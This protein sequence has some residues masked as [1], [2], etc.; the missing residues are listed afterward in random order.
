[1][2]TSISFLSG[3]I[4]FIFIIV[5]SAKNGY[6]A[7]YLRVNI[8]LAQFA[9]ISGLM[10]ITLGFKRTLE[11][12]SSAK[13]FIATTTAPSTLSNDLITTARFS[14]TSSAIWVL[15]FISSGFLIDGEKLSNAAVKSIAISMLYAVIISELYLR[16]VSV[17]ITS[18]TN[19]DET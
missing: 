2:A 15:A 8:L 10:L 9:L 6:V 19:K 7:D 11:V 1:M 16:P 14:Y 4:F 12:L 17:K 13:Y 18:K 3:S 5:I